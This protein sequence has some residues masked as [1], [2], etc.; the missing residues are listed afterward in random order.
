MWK[1]ISGA[2]PATDEIDVEPY[3]K[4]GYAAANVKQENLWYIIDGYGDVSASTLT[5]FVN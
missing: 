3:R 1:W 2:M 5:C 4:I